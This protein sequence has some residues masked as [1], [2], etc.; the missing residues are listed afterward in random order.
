VAGH[1]AIVLGEDRPTAIVVEPAR[2]ACV[3]ATAK[4]GR[5]IAIAHSKPTVMAMLECYEP[6][7]VAWRVLSRLGDAFMT[8]D[9]EDAV[10]VMNRLAR[11]SGTDPAIVSGESGGA[12]LAGL[13]RAAGDKKMRGAL[14]LDAQSRVLIINSEGATDPGRYAELVG[15]APDE[16]ALARQPA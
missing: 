9:E 13:I 4:A 12:G 5:P 6:S 3:Y 16:V 2:A 7:L 1:F 10:S 15:M 8:V 11:P 14:G